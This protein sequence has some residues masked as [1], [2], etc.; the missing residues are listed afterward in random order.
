MIRILAG[1]IP[2]YFALVWLLSL[3]AAAQ[4]ET[5]GR[6]TGTVTDQQGGVI[7]R[8]TISAKNDQTGSEY[9]TISNEVGVYVIPSAPGGS[10]TISIEAQGFRTTVLKDIKVDAGSTVTGDATMQ[11][12]LA[13]EVIV[14]ASKYEEE[15]INAP[16]TATVISEQAIQTMA[17]QNVADLLRT[18]PGFPSLLTVPP[19]PALN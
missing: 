12:G 8:A 7:Q 15:I 9:R 6:L 13:N 14:T 10:Y 1:H 4:S 5:T 3:A 16:T 11:I 17:T 19:T 18:V 2:R